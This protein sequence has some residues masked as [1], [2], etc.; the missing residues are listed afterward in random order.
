MTKFHLAATEKVGCTYLFA[1]K[2]NWRSDRLAEVVTSAPIIY[3]F[4]VKNVSTTY[5]VGSRGTQNGASCLVLVFQRMTHTNRM[6]SDKENK[7]RK[8]S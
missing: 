3:H 1:W 7:R 8:S 5:L 2:S 6:R 4:S